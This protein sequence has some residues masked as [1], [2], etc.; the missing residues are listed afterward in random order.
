MSIEKKRTLTQE[1]INYVLSDI[2]PISGF[3]KIIP[4]LICDK[5]RKKF[6][7]NLNKY[8]IYPSMFP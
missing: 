1:E 4:K 8:E 2:K 3:D 6:V 7:K 5:L